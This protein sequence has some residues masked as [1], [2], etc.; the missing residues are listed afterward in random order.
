MAAP[1]CVCDDL[2]HSCLVSSVASPFRWDEGDEYDQ[3]GRLRSTG[4]QHLMHNR[5]NRLRAK[6]I[7]IAVGYSIEQPERLLVGKREAFVLLTPLRHSLL[8]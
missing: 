8:K 7:N 5:S 4:G 2:R 1:L 6:R 3:L